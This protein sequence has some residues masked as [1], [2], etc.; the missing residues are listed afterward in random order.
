MTDT[1][2]V[3]DH[4]PTTLPAT[5]VEP[6]VTAATAAAATA[7]VLLPVLV[8]LLTTYVGPVPVLVQG[9]LGTLLTGACTFVAGWRARHVDRQPVAS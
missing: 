9:A 7:S 5:A 2:G 4:A 3:A 8:W 1:P 6:K